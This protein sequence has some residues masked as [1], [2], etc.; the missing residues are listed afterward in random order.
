MVGKGFPDSPEE[1][2]GLLFV[3]YNHK[4]KTEVCPGVLYLRTSK[5]LFKAPD[6]PQ[7]NSLLIEAMVLV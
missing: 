2:P 1:I 5:H 4:S 7:S 6:P 3:K